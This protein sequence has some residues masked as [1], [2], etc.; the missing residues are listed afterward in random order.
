M[1]TSSEKPPVITSAV[2]PDLDVVRRFIADMIAKGA[3]AAL[4]TAIAAMAGNDRQPAGPPAVGRAMQNPG[5]LGTMA[6]LVHPAAGV[7]NCSG[8]IPP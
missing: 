4:I 2:E 5:A 7:V 6:R 8:S 3:V 1:S